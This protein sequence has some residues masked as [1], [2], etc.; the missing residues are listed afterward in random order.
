M[1][2]MRVIA[3]CLALGLAVGFVPGAKAEESRYNGAIQYAL[4]KLVSGIHTESLFGGVEVAVTPIR[5]WKSVSG[6]YCREY[7]ITVTEPGAEAQYD[8]QIRCRDDGKWLLV[9]KN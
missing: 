8:R 1:R 7:D 3:A 4:E 9:P 5:T 2:P 6:H